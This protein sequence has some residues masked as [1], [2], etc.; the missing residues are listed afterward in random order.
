[1]MKDGKKFL[2]YKHLY[3]CF[4]LFKKTFKI[5]GLFILKNLILKKRMWFS[6]NKLLLKDKVLYLPRLLSI[7]NQF[8][9]TLKYIFNNFNL[10]ED[11]R[12]KKKPYYKKLFYVLFDEFICQKKLNSLMKKQYFILNKHNSFIL[13]E[14]QRSRYIQSR[15]VGNKII[16]FRIKKK[17]ITR[18][19]KIYKRV[20]RNITRKYVGFDR[21]NTNIWLGIKSGFNYKYNLNL[22]SRLKLK[23]KWTTK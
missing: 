18:R 4:Y 10:R 17:S 19:D 1:M 8:S 2:A 11:K 21:F 22:I 23:K 14:D 16:H 5:N 15:K 12:F 6:L 7:R 9:R 13:N 3:K 20:N